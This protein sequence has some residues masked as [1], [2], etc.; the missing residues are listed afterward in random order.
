[1]VKSIRFS[2]KIILLTGGTG[3]LGAAMASRILESGAKLIVTSRNKKNLLKF[4]SKLKNDQ[5]KNV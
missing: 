2:K 3:Y 5:K 1:M 4:F